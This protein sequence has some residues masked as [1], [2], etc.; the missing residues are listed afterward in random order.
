VAALAV[1]L[2]ALAAL[3]RTRAQLIAIGVTL[4]AGVPA[5]IAAE[6]FDG[7]RALQG[8]LP[9]RESDGL[10]MLA[11]LLALAAAAAAATWLWARLPSRPI[12]LPRWAPVAVAVAVIA[13]SG[14]VVAVAAR[15]RGHPAAAASASAQ[16]LQSVE[17]SR[18]DY[19]KVAL[20]HGFEP[21]P[22]EG[23]G[24][25]G[26]AVVWL[27]FRDVRER[28]KVAHSLYVETLAELGIVGFAIL[29]LFLGGLT[30]AAARALRI[31]PARA[32]GP[33][34]A[35]V[36]WA[37]HSAIDWD[38]QMPALTLVALVLAGMLIATSE[39]DE[40]VAA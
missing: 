7:V 31:D 16:R 20:E 36:I 28:A 17:S 23:I 27:E 11:I 32:V 5:A 1:G 25:G 21:H 12:V 9:A 22:L 2:L 26:F 10:A 38:W 14:A 19:W 18:Y 6:G 30:L 13:V 39:A 33:A 34:A 8:S 37:T 15:D 4:A 35:L 24:A 3:S 29:A 40:A